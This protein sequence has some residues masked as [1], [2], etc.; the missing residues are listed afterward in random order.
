MTSF[1]DSIVGGFT[2]PKAGESAS[3]GEQPMRGG[4][5]DP[6]VD[7]AKGPGQPVARWVPGNPVKGRE[8]FDR[9]S[10]EAMEWAMREGISATFSSATF[11]SMPADMRARASKVD[12]LLNRPD[13][14][15]ALPGCDCP[16]CGASRERYLAGIKSAPRTQLTADEQIRAQAAVAAGSMCCNIDEAVQVVRWFEEYIRTGNDGR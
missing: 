4:Y 3:V 13:I 7:I 14:P 16:H 5:T 12:E 9:I 11:S 1:Q 10:A 6:G 15:G 2:M 8:D